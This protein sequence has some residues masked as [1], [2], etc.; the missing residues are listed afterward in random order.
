MGYGTSRSSSLVTIV[1]APGR[2]CE[3]EIVIVLWITAIGDPHGRLKPDGSMA[4]YFQDPLT[5]C[6]RNS[7]RKPGTVQN[8]G[9]LAIDR[10]REREH[11]D[12]LGMQQRALRNAVRLE[13]RTYEG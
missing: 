12:F 7:T 13:R 5:P 1:S 8:P 3:L 4:Q 2:D 11:I 9:N 10:G 6:K